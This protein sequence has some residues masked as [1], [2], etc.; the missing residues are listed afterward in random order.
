MNFHL[1]I[2]W[3]SQLICEYVECV[4]LVI[5]EVI[6]MASIV[7]GIWDSSTFIIYLVIGFA[8]FFKLHVIVFSY[9]TLYLTFNKIFIEVNLYIYINIIFFL[10]NYKKTHWIGE[11]KFH[12]LKILSNAMMCWWIVFL[13]IMLQLHHIPFFIVLP[14]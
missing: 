7:C 3:H 4:L 11:H 9:V 1:W 5:K 2:V 6:K 10:F 13:G 8:S 14:C 12:L